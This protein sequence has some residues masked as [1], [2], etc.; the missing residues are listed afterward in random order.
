MKLHKQKTNSITSANSVRNDIQ[1][2]Y[3]QMK[4]V[5]ALI[6]KYISGSDMTFNTAVDYIYSLQERQQLAGAIIEIKTLTA[7]LESTYGDLIND[8]TN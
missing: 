8:T 2:A 4:S 3:R 7:T 6:D 5:S 1:S